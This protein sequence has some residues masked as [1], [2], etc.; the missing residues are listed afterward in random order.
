RPHAD[1]SPGQVREAGVAPGQAVE[2]TEV[3]VQPEDRAEGTPDRGLHVVV[4]GATRAAELNPQFRYHGARSL[5]YGDLERVVVHDQ[6][7]TVAGAVEA[8]DRIVRS[9]A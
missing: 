8:I 3:H 6:R 4:H 1:E 5:P 7:A 2:V 9:T